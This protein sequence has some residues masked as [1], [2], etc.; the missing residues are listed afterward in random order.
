MLDDLKKER[1][2]GFGTKERIRL[3]LYA[4][5][6]VAI[7][8][9]IVSQ[10]SCGS[11]RGPE[12]LPLA[13]EDPA[14]VAA[15]AGKHVDRSR[16]ASLVGDQPADHARWSAAAL[17]YLVPLAE[18]TLADGPERVTADELAARPFGAAQGGVFEVAGRVTDLVSEEYPT[19][20]ERLWSVALTGPEGGLVIA[21]RKALASD[22]K[23]GAP[24]DEFRGATTEIRPGDSVVVRGIL[25]QRR[26]G[27]VGNTALRDPVPVLVAMAFRKVPPRA[28]APIADPSEA[29]WEGVKDRFMRETESWQDPAF[30]E[31]MQWMRLKGQDAL[32]QEIRSGKI[33]VSTWDQATFTKWSDEVVV[34][35]PDVPRPFI[36]AHRGKVF[37]TTGILGMIEKNGW[38]KIQGNAWGVDEIYQYHVMSDHYGNASIPFFSPFAPSEFDG[39]KGVRAENVRAYGLFLKNYSYATK[40]QGESEGSYRPIT[41]PLF[42][43]IHMETLPPFS[44]RSKDMDTVIWVVTGAIA[45]FA[46]VFYFVLI[47]SERKESK[48]MDDRRRTIRKRTRGSGKGGAPGEDAGAGPPAA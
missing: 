35:S 39:F 26:T 47:R 29:D 48:V 27:T 1:Q 3:A 17:E 4:A 46:F 7:A 34:K 36:D 9:F 24:H 14:T 43:L 45:I 8:G 21:V 15:R 38:D 18:G 32:L 41:M 31:L 42:L 23:E 6:L 13:P 2:A 19:A 37:S 5:M 22:H 40:H 33:P 12:D 28:A 10:R 16:L 20:A 25:A 11:V 30:F 44:P